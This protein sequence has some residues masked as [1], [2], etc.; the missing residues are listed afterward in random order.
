MIGMKKGGRRVLVLPPHL[1]YG[2][3]GVE[4]RVPPNATL[5]FDLTI[6]KYKV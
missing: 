3:V 6:L 1:S 5:I 2:D 4:G